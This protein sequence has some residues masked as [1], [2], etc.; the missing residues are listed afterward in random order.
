[1]QEGQMTHRTNDKPDIG[2]SGDKQVGA[3]AKAPA[4]G[5]LGNDDNLKEVYQQ[6]CDSYRAIDD[7]RMKLLGLLP[8][9]TGAGIVVLTDGGKSTPAKGLSASI[10]IFGLVATIGL[11]SY[12]LHGIKKCAYMID[13]GKQIEKRLNI[14]GQFQRRP[15][16]VA[17]FIDEPFAASIIYPAAL[18]GWLFFALLDLPRWVGYVSSAVVPVAG[19]SVS[20]WL[21]RAMEKD[22]DNRLQYQKEAFWPPKRKPKPPLSLP[23]DAYIEKPDKSGH[24]ALGPGGH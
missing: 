22:V 14:Y 9:A 6:L 13:A 19:V 16:E 18:A 17:G 5:L 10:G 8:I 20:V 23:N 12:E 15:H 2:P 1:M 3:A 7:I 11:F 21:I 4:D 24:S